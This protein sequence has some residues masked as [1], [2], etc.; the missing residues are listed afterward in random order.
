LRETEP[1]HTGALTV[2]VDDED[3]VEVLVLVVVLVVLPLC[4]SVDPT[5]SKSINKTVVHGFDF[6]SSC[7]LNAIELGYRRVMS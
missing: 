4:P 1:S 3:V 6:I 2:V 5:M 7:E